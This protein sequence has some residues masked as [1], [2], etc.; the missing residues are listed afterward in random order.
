MS[1]TDSA[2]V[3][4]DSYMGPTTI[5]T[6]VSIPGQTHPVANPQ[7]PL[8]PSDDMRSHCELLAV[9]ERGT[10]RCGKRW[11][12]QDQGY[13]VGAAGHPLVKGVFPS[14]VD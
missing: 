10:A 6:S 14:R 13:G 5:A 2:E 8:Q 11:C 4:D 9:P 3:R 1:H 12:E 7:G